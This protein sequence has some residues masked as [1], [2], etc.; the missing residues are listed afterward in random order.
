MQVRPGRNRNYAASNTV[1]VEHKRR[2]HFQKDT[3]K[4]LAYSELHTHTSRLKNSRSFVS[5]DPRDCCCAHPLDATS[6]NNEAEEFYV[7]WGSE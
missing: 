5:N 7:F 1:Q 4:D 2:L 3:E 6:F